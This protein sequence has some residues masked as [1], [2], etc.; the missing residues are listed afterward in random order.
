MKAM[1]AADRKFRKRMEDLYSLL[2]KSQE[3][4]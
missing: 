1:I 4:T 2:T 3:Q